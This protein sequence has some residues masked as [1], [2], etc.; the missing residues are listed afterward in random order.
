VKHAD[1][2][3]YSCRN[4]RF[5]PTQEYELASDRLVCRTYS[6]AT[7]LLF[8]EIAEIVVFKEKL[9]GSSR[10][11]WACTVRCKGDIVK[12]TSAHRANPVTIEDQVASY[13]PFIK[14]FERAALTANPDIRFIDDE[15]RETMG[16]RLLGFLSLWMAVLLGLFPRRQAASI[17]GNVLSQIGPLLR[18]HRHA[19]RQLVSAFPGLSARQVTGVL[20]KM[21]DNIGRTFAEYSHAQELMRSFLPD[22]SGARPVIVID[23]S[24][25]ANLQHL[26]ADP[27]GALMFA[28][29]L[30]NWEIPAMAAQ[31]VGRKIALVYK[32][33][34]SRIMT[35]QLV[36]FRACFAAQLVEAGPTAPREILKLLRDGWLVGMLVDQHYA[37]GVKINF[38]NHACVVN[39]ILG[40]LARIYDWPVYGARAVR[41]PDQR[42]RFELV[43]PLAL[44]RDHSG[45]IAV[46]GAMQA[47]MNLIENWIREAPEQWMWI[48]R[49]IR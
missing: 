30:G 34:P 23:D 35:E 28:A 40:R 27:R 25:A 24:T 31:A 44:P 18:G 32:R 48:H 22:V 46:E 11:Y 19:R 4:R 10:S 36:Q 7:D 17:C 14:E 13:I 6:I 42:H 37:K 39:P 3:R 49:L 43:G 26:G 1:S 16:T 41:L 45:R 33:Q 29:H 8:K 20:R 47:V 2:M 15:F 12:I 5:G 21:W 38:F 9:L